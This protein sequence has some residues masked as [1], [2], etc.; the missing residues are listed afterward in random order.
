MIFSAIF[1]AAETALTTVPESL[2]RKI[3][4][5]KSYFTAPFK[6]W[7]SRPNA[8]LTAIIIGN[9][10]VNTLAA[11]VATVFAQKLF[12][13]FVI[14]IATTA[15]TLLLLIVGEITPKTYARHNAK[16]VL[17][18]AVNFVY[19]TYFILY[20]VVVILSKLS[21]IF[22][23]AIGGKTKR[24]GP[25]TTEE[26]INYLIKMGHEEGVFKQSHG[27]MLESVIELRDTEVRE[28]IIP[29]K[30]ISS[31]PIDITYE[32]LLKEI[33]A[34]GYTR[35]PV[36]EE[37]IDHVV[38]VFYSKDL[39]NYQANYPKNFRLKDHLRKIIF[40]PE[41]MKLDAILKE[42][43]KQKQHL[44][45]V[46]DEYGGTAG[47]VTLEDI[48]EEIVGEIRDEL[49]KEEEEQTVITL[50][51][52]HFLVDGRTSIL[53]LEKQTSIALPEE[54]SYESVG[55]FLVASFGKIPEKDAVFKHKDWS[56]KVVEVEETRVVKVEIT[57]T[58]E[59][60]NNWEQNEQ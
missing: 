3:I 39:I 25:V 47:L 31:L 26:D 53:E 11:V 22:I 9:N 13:E 23:H 10:L 58:I 54:E 32:E 28:I 42:F 57:Q 49:D 7:L 43:Q 29:R 16:G 15:V 17:T 8:V 60:T 24:T 2:I 14:G 55:G 38:G 40:I 5:E 46:V 48:L 6:L 50:G 18:W 51:E 37:D 41:S 33:E 20:P 30:D 12:S 52:K 1:S 34:H 35:W 45:I 56:F 19:C 21:I 44:A 4:D 27:Q 59:K 36:Y